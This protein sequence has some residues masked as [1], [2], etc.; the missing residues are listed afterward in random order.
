M[1]VSTLQ[2]AAIV[3]LLV[4][5]LSQRFPHSVED[6]GEIFLHGIGLERT[7][8]LL[9]L[10]GHHVGGDQVGDERAGPVHDLVL[11]VEVEFRTDARGIE[12][13][14]SL[15]DIAGAPVNGFLL[16][17]AGNDFR[18]GHAGDRVGIHAADV[19]LHMETIAR[20][21]RAHGLM[22]LLQVVV[23]AVGLCRPLF[24]MSDDALQILDAI[25]AG[26]HVVVADA[27]G[28]AAWILPSSLV[29]AVGQSMVVAERLTDFGAELLGFFPWIL[30]FRPILVAPFDGPFVVDIDAWEQ[31]ALRHAVLGLSYIVEACIVHDAHR[32]AIGLHPLLVAKL[33]HGCGAAG[34]HV[35]AQSQRVANL[36]GR[37]KAD[38]LAH[39]LVGQLHG[40]STLIE[41]PALGDIPF[42]YE[43]HHV[44]IPADMALDDLA[45]ARVNDTRTIGVL[46]FGRQIAQETVACV[47]GTDV[48]ALGHFTGNDGV[49]KS[50]SLKGSVPVVDAG[51]EIGHP[52]LWRCRVDIVDDLL[53]RFHELALFIGL[54]VLGLQA[55]AVDDGIAFRGRTVGEACLTGLEKTDTVVGDTWLHRLLG[56][57]HDARVHADG[58][59]TGP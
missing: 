26:F 6:V 34:D 12:P 11:S 40:L 4:A 5:F 51:D 31:S 48:A 22:H 19:A 3:V 7:L 15:E 29:T 45:A 35:V 25:V 47:V 28:L 36:M 10:V 17:V 27:L 14:R 59:K 56:Q 8:A 52:F 13:Q 58:D 50:G 42:A 39:E 54:R 20:K 23:L 46:R 37:D 18:D 43:V 38:E 16:H 49:F 24:E 55:I 32:V 33:L 9:V 44:V 30:E 53:F 1:D 2:L 41:R 21:L 57:E